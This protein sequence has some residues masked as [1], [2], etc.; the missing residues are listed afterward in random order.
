MKGKLF[1]TA[2]P[3]LVLALALIGCGGDDG[4]GGGYQAPLVGAVYNPSGNKVTLPAAVAAVKAADA[5]SLIPPQF[6]YGQT[7]YAIAGNQIA[8]IRAAGGTPVNWN[9]STASDEFWTD[10][11]LTNV[12]VDVE[13]VSGTAANAYLFAYDGTN[14]FEVIKTGFFGLYIG[15]PITD[16]NTVS[17]LTFAAT[18]AGSYSFRIDIVEVDEDDGAIIGNA[19]ASQTLT[20]NVAADPA[21]GVLYTPVADVVSLPAG[22]V[23]TVKAADANSLIPNQFLYGQTFY[24]VA[25]NQI[26]AIRNAG[27]EPVTWDNSAVTEGIWSN[28]TKNV[29]I[30]VALIS[31]NT[32]NAYLFAYDG[33][34]T[35]EVIKTGFF[36]LYI[37]QQLSDFQTVSSLTFAATA[38]GIYTFRIDI[39]EV[40]TEGVKSATLGSQTV[41]IVAE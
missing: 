13:L 15:Q 37:G 38:A 25:G 28:T 19:L 16:L 14:T 8:A 32:A 23:A 24:A 39:V 3:V 26:A 5:N 21:I 7:F 2:V 33:T 22:D 17:S 1:S 12:R 20:V 18:A 31:G 34:N 10:A 9:H 41:T 40:N 36:G 35:F 27:G 6:L 30:D 29:R 4:G 11:T